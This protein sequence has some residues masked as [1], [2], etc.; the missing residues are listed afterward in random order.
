MIDVTPTRVGA[1]PTVVLAEH[2]PLDSANKPTN[3]CRRSIAV[4]SFLRLDP[5]AFE[6]HAEHDTSGVRQRVATG[7]CCRV[8]LGHGGP[9]SASCSTGSLL[10]YDLCRLRGSAPKRVN[11]IPKAPWPPLIIAVRMMS[12]GDTGKHEEDI[13]RELTASELDAVSGGQVGGSLTQTLTSTITQMAL[14]TATNSGTI[15]ASATTT[16]SA[17]AAGA[18]AVASNSIGT[19]VQM[20]SVS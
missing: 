12:S 6:Q 19:I 8:R 13:M 14:V 15:T 3:A 17:T 4:P 1:L 9:R 11:Q 18:E 5:A 7:G 10:R 20:N 16:G 2:P